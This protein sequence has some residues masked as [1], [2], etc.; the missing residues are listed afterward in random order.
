MVEEKRG[1]LRET[2]YWKDDVDYVSRQ[3]WVHPHQFIRR[4]LG[5]PGEIMDY[6]IASSL[7]ITVLT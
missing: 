6:N 1:S 7:I 3:Y 5:N 2:W 4:N